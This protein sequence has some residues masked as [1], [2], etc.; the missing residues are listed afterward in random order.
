MTVVD[1]IAGYWPAREETVESCAARMLGF[2]D[3]LAAIDASLSHWSTPSS[4]QRVTPTSWAVDT[5]TA[6]LL[7]G[8]NRN[9][10]DQAVIESLGY[11]MV[12]R[13]EANEDGEHARL[14]VTCG[15]TSP[16]VKNVAVLNL[17]FRL[18][19]SPTITLELTALLAHC[20][21]PDWALAVSGEMRKAQRTDSRGK[22]VL[23][24]HTYL[25][26][27]RG[28]VP[29][30]PVPFSVQP[31]DDSGGVIVSITDDD[32]TPLLPSLRAMLGS[33]LEAPPN[34]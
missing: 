23:G 29:P 9:D 14:S 30:L 27:S 12:L 7:K 20:W 5:L 11:S 31:L 24:T 2:L 32:A 13:T 22:L 17:P 16:R 26:P 8:Q 3:G 21:E 6:E 10:R 28:P 19:A 4:T 25:A 1:Q 15:V 33:L 34:S 18:G